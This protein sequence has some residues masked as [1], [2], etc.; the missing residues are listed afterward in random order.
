MATDR[1]VRLTPDQLALKAATREAV[2]AAGGQDHVAR[3]V[4]RAQSRI[5]DYCSSN[6]A[7]FMPLDIIARVEELGAGSPGHP[8]ITR[9]LARRQGD[10]VLDCG[11]GGERY[12]LAQ[13]L[14]EVAGESSDVIRILAEGA[15][16]SD[17]AA[18]SIASM[19]PRQRSELARELDGLMQVLSDIN[20]Q[21]GEA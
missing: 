18:R 8:H 2:K 13:L 5:S 19:G 3:E 17:A 9:A 21:I 15:G 16:S 14:A 4:G 6:A 7:E 10:M 1:T 20:N 11:D 12:P